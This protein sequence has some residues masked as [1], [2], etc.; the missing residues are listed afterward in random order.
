MDT[1]V[2]EDTGEIVTST[3]RRSP[4]IAKLA[5]ALAKAQGQLHN[6]ARDADGNFGKYPTL[7]SVTDAIRPILSQEGIATYQSTTSHGTRINVTTLLAHSSGEYLESDTVLTV[8]RD[9]VHQQCGGFTY[10][11]RYALQAAVGLAPE[12]DDGQVAQGDDRPAHATQ[13]AP[14]LRVRKGQKITAAQASRI[15][16]IAKTAGQDLDELRAYFQS[17]GWAATKD[18]PQECF[19][20]VCQKIEAGTLPAPQADDGM[21]SAK[22]IG[23]AVFGQ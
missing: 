23:E 15:F 5:T 6:V 7:G 21:T 4:S 1:Q 10:A 3:I 19:E 20:E 9:A 16:T 11:R 8:A 2:H 18:M 17:R 22:E 14:D 12:D 13:K